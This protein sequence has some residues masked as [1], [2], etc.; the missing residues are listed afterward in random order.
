MQ[1]IDGMHLTVQS[2]QSVAAFC[3]EKVFHHLLVEFDCDVP[4]LEDNI[5][6]TAE[7]YRNFDKQM[8]WN[9]LCR[10]KLKKYTDMFEPCS[11]PAEGPLITLN[12]SDNPMLHSVTARGVQGM[13]PTMIL[14]V[15]SIPVR[16][17]QV[18]YFS[19]HGES[20][21]NVLG[22]IGGDADL[23][24]RGQRYAERLTKYLASPNVVRP[25]MV[26]AQRP[27]PRAMC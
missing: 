9:Y 12:N 17:H 20:D 7:F 25:K 27:P 18:Y 1:I 24:L 10:E 2:R 8:N 13:L 14:G 15:L 3:H 11:M 23:S 6:E 26:T 4:D 21:Y 19:R 16:K 5:R 22:R